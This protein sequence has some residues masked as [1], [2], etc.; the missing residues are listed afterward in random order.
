MRPWL[1][2][3]DLFVTPLRHGG[4]TRL[5]ILEALAAECPVVSSRKGAE[6]LDLQHE[7][8]LLL[9]DDHE[10]FVAAVLAALANPGSAAAMARCGREHVIRH[11]S[12]DVSRARIKDAVSALPSRESAAAKVCH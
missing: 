1:A 6:G 12:W 4:G 9:A 8:H 11:Y 7:R 3:A 2:D 5:K 10:A